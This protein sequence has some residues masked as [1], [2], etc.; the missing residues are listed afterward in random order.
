MQRLSSGTCAAGAGSNLDKSHWGAE[1]DGTVARTESERRSG[2]FSLF[3][4]VCCAFSSFGIPTQKRGPEALLAA[5]KHRVSAAV[6]PG[7]PELPQL[8]RLFNGSAS[9]N[10]SPQHDTKGGD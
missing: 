9:C 2:L 6:P 5:V 1:A 10:N 8:E 4:V 7:S 3:V